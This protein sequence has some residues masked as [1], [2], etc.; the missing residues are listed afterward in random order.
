MA[1]SEG[2]DAATQDNTTEVEVASLALSIENGCDAYSTII[3]KQDVIEQLV[4][5]IGDEP[6]TFALDKVFGLD[7]SYCEQKFTFEVDCVDCPVA[8]EAEAGIAVIDGNT[9]RVFTT[10]AST[11]GRYGF[12]IKA[13]SAYGTIKAIDLT[14]E[15]RQKCRDVK[16]VVTVLT[17]DVLKMR[18]G[19]AAATLD[20]FKVTFEQAHCQDVG[21]ETTSLLGVNELLVPFVTIDGTQLK[22][23]GASHLDVSL[24]GDYSFQVELTTTAGQVEYISVDLAISDGLC[25]ALELV[26]EPQALPLIKFDIAKPSADNFKVHVDKSIEECPIV[27]DGLAVV[28]LNA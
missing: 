25:A 18:L 23:S 21:V 17:D 2:P 1:Q 28:C 3:L 24:I 11:T 19:D 8:S 20:L 14:V 15:I 26:L 4:F 27:V 9:L 22:F 16:P 10:D 12:D 5:E 6:L 13:K 7:K